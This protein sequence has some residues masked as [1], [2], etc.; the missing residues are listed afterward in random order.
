VWWKRA[1]CAWR[2]PSSPKGRRRRRG[3]HRRS[4]ELATGSPEPSAGVRERR[5]RR[6]RAGIRRAVRILLVN[7]ND[8][9]TRTP[10][11]PK[12]TCTRSSAGWSAGACR[13]PRGQR[14]PGCTPETVLDGIRVRRFGGTH[15][16][17]LRAP[18][19]V[20]RL[21]HTHAYD[22]VV[23]DINKLPLYLTRLTHLPFYV[24][25]PSVRHDGVRRA[26]WPIAATVWAAERLIPPRVPRARRFTRSPTARAMTWYGGA[27]GGSGSK[28]FTRVSMPCGT[29]RTRPPRRAA[30][31]RSC[32]WAP[33]AL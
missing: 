25:V 22:V 21:L 8:A 20:R 24:I 29:P 11:A 33:Q 13:R 4:S 12:S 27:S 6:G 7:W 30:T 10:A 17:A 28:S 19:A 16:F 15:T 32:M 9:R 18:G 26:S 23:E 2:S 3:R 5:A 31:R 1:S 14:W